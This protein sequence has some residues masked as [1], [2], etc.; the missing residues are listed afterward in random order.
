MIELQKIALKNIVVHKNTSLDI[1]KEG[2]YVIRGDNGAGK[3]LFFSCIPNVFDGCPPLLKK[4]DAK[5]IHGDDS[6]IGIK[7]RY[8]NKQYRVVQAS[9][10]GS[11]S[12]KI[13]EDG[14]ELDPRT[15]SIA[16]ECLEK[17]FPISTAQYYNLVHLMAYRPSV[18]LYGSGTQR[19]E[20]FEELFHMDINEAI[21]EKIKE[22]YNSLKR[23]ND[24]KDLLEEQLKELTF[25]DNIEELEKQYENLNTQY[26]TYKE[27]YDSYANQIQISASLKTY[28]SQ[29]QTKYSFEEIEEN[30]PQVESKIS[31]LE[32]SLQDMKVNQNLWKRNQENIKRK[33]ELEAELETYKEI[34]KDSNS[35]KEEYNTLKGEAENLKE[36][37]LQARSNNEL[38]NKFIEL[39]NKVG[40]IVKE[41]SYEDY[42][43]KITKAESKVEETEK[44]LRKLQ[45]LIGVAKC[46]T[47]QQELNKEDLDNLIN[48]CNENIK[49]QNK[50]LENK[51]DCLSFIKLR[52]K[53]L[54]LIEEET[55]AQK[56]E[57][58]KGKLQTLKE[59]HEK[60]RQK[61][62]LEY[63]L[64]IFP[65]ILEIE[66][67][68]DSAIQ[69]TEDKIEKG[70]T[71]L[72]KLKSDL[73][74]KKEIQKLEQKNADLVNEGDAQAEMEKLSTLMENINEERMALHSKIN[75]GKSQ[76]LAYKEKE[77]RIKGITGKLEKMPIYEAL[78]KAYGAKGIRV[79][80]IKYLADMF[81]NNLNKY[82]SLVFNK[83]IKF[84][85][86]VDSTNFNILAERNGGMI[87]DVCTLSGA[88][89]RFFCLLCAISLLPFIPEKYRTDFIILDE[90]EAGV[91]T[92]NRKFL[93]QGFFKALH[94]IVPKVIIVTPVDREE[95]YIEADKEYY[96]KLENNVSVMEEI[97]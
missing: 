25:I 29:I 23:L 95:Y 14:K 19:K 49:E 60:A 33:Q 62:N 43:T 53:N 71:F 22:E 38:Y 85:V 28:I 26:K 75:I 72:L 89:S 45:N 46:P 2:I 32:T 10:K 37:L 36:K 87:S 4:K 16:K 94:E 55:L 65:E 39:K 58:I 61:E 63:Q 5:V 67:P 84:H 74:V 24:E 96:I 81:C 83:E 93:T 80:Q 47:C 30:I 56:I 52:D 7:Y 50:C 92:K 9:R 8:N 64:S 42:L 54:S 18:L 82:A 76:N 51:E 91:K 41:Q 13:E 70:K 21:A 88:E 1:S 90:M 48:S 78:T 12:Y 68:E 6:A 40:E 79:D 77:E 34:T 17:V 97:K 35:I 59:D 11:L 20:F 57:E 15:I 27:S 86:N 66:K 73:K 44:I 31:K 69:E 3:S